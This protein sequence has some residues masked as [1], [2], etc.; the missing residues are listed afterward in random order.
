M[1]VSLYIL[2]PHVYIY[3]P[4]SSFSSMVWH[5]PQTPNIL[6][7]FLKLKRNYFFLPD[8]SVSIY[9]VYKD[10]RNLP[11]SKL[12]SC[13]PDGHLA[14]WWA[15]LVSLLSSTITPA[16]TRRTGRPSLLEHQLSFVYSACAAVL[17]I[18]ESQSHLGPWQHFFLS[19]EDPK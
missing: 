12:N 19:S 1:F 5:A 14:L 11:N 13:F 8:S 9:I 15:L 17:L 18:N 6:L 16:R 10:S 7:S 4:S 3:P 2:L